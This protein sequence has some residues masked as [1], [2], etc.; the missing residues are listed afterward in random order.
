MMRAI[1]G[2][3]TQFIATLLLAA[4]A[5]G[6]GA[7]W[8]HAL[9]L[10]GHF[11]LHL[12]LAAAPVL[13]LALIVR[14]WTAAW[15]ALVALVLAVAGLSPVWEQP[16]PVT[17][18][19]PLSVLTANL[20][21]DNPETDAMVGAL[22]AADADILV[23]HETTKAALTATHPLSDLYPYR[24]ALSTRGR[25]LRTVIWSKYPM[26]DG[27]LLL[28]DTV[29]PTGA[30]AIVQLPDG[31][32]VSVVGLHLAHAWPGNQDRQIA[33][34][35]EITAGLPRPMIVVG[36]FNTAP[37]SHAM[38]LVQRMT[39]TRRIPGYRVTWHGTYPEPFGGLPAL[40]GHAIDHV[41]LSPG[42][43]VGSVSVVAIPGSDHDAVG[44]TI[45]LPGA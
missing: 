13:V 26:R 34:L 3:V 33:V 6:Y 24:L 11:R 21:H 31:R 25:I 35:G 10:V 12:A 18:G 36:D 40:L 29:E 32:E 7:A 8:F 41:L 5:L 15:R 9:D 42:L 23:T 4:V 19:Q 39:G 2:G 38:A 43:G 30:I 45:M 17:E 27:T 44:A 37:W 28:E 20:S 1:L 22:R 16:T 14:R